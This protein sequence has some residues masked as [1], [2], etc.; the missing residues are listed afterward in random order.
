M[1]R[2]GIAAKART[3][4]LEDIHDA[5]QV[6]VHRPPGMAW[7]LVSHLRI[8]WRQRP[9]RS[10]RS[11]RERPPSPRA[12]CSCEPESR[13]IEHG[14]IVRALGIPHDVNNFHQA[15]APLTACLA[16]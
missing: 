7:L 2:V 1:P 15:A 3:L 4:T 12:A 16:P 5:A 10:A 11:S 14:K 13:I 9:A 8:E 6:A